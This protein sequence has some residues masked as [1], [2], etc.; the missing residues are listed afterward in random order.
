MRTRSPAPPKCRWA[1]SRMRSCGWEWRKSSPSQS[2]AGQSRSS[3]PGCRPTVSMR[4]RFGGIWRWY[5]QGDLTLTHC[6]ITANT[7][8]SQGGGIEN[9]QG[10][11]LTIQGGTITITRHTTS[12]G[13][14]LED[15]IAHSQWGDVRRQPG[16]R[17]GRGFRRQRWGRVRPG[18][19]PVHGQY[20][21]GRRRLSNSNRRRRHDLGVAAL[22]GTRS[23][24]ARCDLRLERIADNLRTRPSMGTPWSMVARSTTVKAV[25]RRSRRHDQR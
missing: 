8:G 13:G 17:L 14:V 6:T 1:T 5:N 9:A 10:A 3:N 4:E 22:T 25:R 18:I 20:G 15:G 16:R 21:R 7:A 24:A 12:G 23:P 2:R 19:L 11:M